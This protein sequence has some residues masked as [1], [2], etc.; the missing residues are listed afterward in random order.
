MPPNSTARDSRFSDI[1]GPKIRGIKQTI[2][3]RLYRISESLHV[4]CGYDAPIFWHGENPATFGPVGG[5][6]PTN[7]QRGWNRT[8]QDLQ[9]RLNRIIPRGNDR[10]YPDARQAPS[11]EAVLLRRCRIRRDRNRRRRLQIT[12]QGLQILGQTFQDTLPRW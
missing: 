2:P 9:N 8:V 10:G 11:V 5:P 6:N 12:G 7:W 3:Q 4:L 1:P